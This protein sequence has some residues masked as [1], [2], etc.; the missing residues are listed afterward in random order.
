MT[1]REYREHEGVSRSELF[2]IISKT[3]LH[4]KYSLEHKEEPSAAMIFG[5]AAHKYVLEKK[6]FFEEYA[7][8]PAVDR[9]T[10]EGKEIYNSFVADSVGKTVI[11]E[12]DYIKI[13]EMSE[14]I[15][16]NPFAREFLTGE[17]EQ[18]FFWTDSET[19]EICKVRPDC[20]SEVHGKKY[21]VDYKTTDSCVDGHFEKSAR[22]FGYKMQ[23]GMYREG[24]FNN[25]FEDYG[26]VFVAQEKAAPYAVRVYICSDEF[27]EEGCD[28]FRE[29]LAIYADCKKTGNWYGYETVYGVTT[30][31]LGEGE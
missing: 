22:K 21:I 17:C 26:F 24:L 3:P 4:Y 1:N 18:S 6:D 16:A 29:A 11:T 13:I 12:A 2:T 7:V 25:T 9:R 10:K 28:Q 27:M 30:P 15:D 8:A 5:S 14:A 19:G 31:L 20:I 23:A